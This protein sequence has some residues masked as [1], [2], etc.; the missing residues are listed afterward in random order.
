[1]SEQ[2]TNMKIEISVDNERDVQHT[3]ESKDC[4]KI[5]EYID[6]WL[7][8]YKRKSGGVEIDS[9]DENKLKE[10]V[11]S[12]ESNVKI[13]N[14]HKF[15]CD[16]INESVKKKILNSET[17]IISINEDNNFLSLDTVR[18]LIKNGLI[19][20]NDIQIAD[21]QNDN[22][23]RDEIMGLLSNDYD[24]TPPS[25]PKD[26][27]QSDKNSISTQLY[28]WGLPSSGKTCVLGSLMSFL[29][30]AEGCVKSCKPDGESPGYVYMHSNNGRSGIVDVFRLN[31]RSRTILLPGSTPPE[32]S[33]NTNYTLKIDEKEYP[34][35]IVDFA[36]ET[37]NKIYAIVT[38]SHDNNKKQEELKKLM[39]ILFENKRHKHQMHFFLLDYCN[40]NYN[41]Q[42]HKLLQ[43]VQYIKNEGLFDDNTKAIS[44]IVTKIDKTGWVDKKD[45]KVAAEQFVTQQYANIRGT[46]TSINKSV[47]Q[48]EN[49]VDIIPYSI[50]RLYFRRI[51]VPDTT[52]PEELFNRIYKYGLCPTPS[53]FW[54]KLMER[55][56]K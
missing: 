42:D 34:V 19:S 56:R 26:K 3:T 5:N 40:D 4:E 36:G 43:T 32:Y 17:I 54:S 29:L 49:M 33:Y 38:K 41:E 35:T 7:K 31:N 25:M 44:V 55:F 23:L 1:M 51:C 20:T 48:R 45:Q 9:L 22:E 2:E 14:K 11:N 10:I 53:G 21:I 24:H 47:L 15:I 50:G 46:L 27:L 8:Y 6:Y 13:S 28:F 16:F 37:L 12:I 18:E 39:P 30:K 52:Y